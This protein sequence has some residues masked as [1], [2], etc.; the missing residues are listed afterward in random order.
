MKLE[1]VSKE[2]IAEEN[3][4]EIQERDY[5]TIIMDESDDVKEPTPVPDTI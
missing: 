4:K 1:Q 2:I 3:Q 5:E